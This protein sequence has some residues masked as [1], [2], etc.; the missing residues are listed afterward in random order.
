VDVEDGM[1][2]RLEHRLAY[3][4]HESRETDQ[5][6]VARLQLGHDRAVEVV[7]RRESAMWD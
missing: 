3:Q 2:K 7:P 6:D 5:T 4:A 1:R